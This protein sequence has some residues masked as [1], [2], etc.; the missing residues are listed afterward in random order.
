MYRPFL[1]ACVSASFLFC[2]FACEEANAT[3]EG[4][5]YRQKMFLAKRFVNKLKEGMGSA[6][7][8]MQ[9]LG[10]RESNILPDGEVLLLQP[11][12][13]RDR[14]RLDEVIYAYVH[15]QKILISLNDLSDVMRLAIDV[16]GRAARGW[17]LQEGRSFDLD[18]DR[19]TT[20]T[21]Q[22]EF[23]LSPD[24]LARDGDIFIPVDEVQAWMGI[25]F[26]VSVS[27]QEVKMKGDVPFPVEEEIARRK[28]EGNRRRILPPSLP[29]A[30]D[31]S[32][33]IGLPVVDVST[34][35][36]YRKSGGADKGIDNHT[37]FVATTGDFAYGTLSTQSRFVNEKGLSSFRA[38]YKVESVEN[39]LL[40]PVKA[41]RVDIGDVTTTSLPIIG[42]NGQELGM[43]ITNTDP[44]RR[45]LHPQ[46]GISGNAIPGWDVELYRE[47]QYIGLQRVGDDGFYEFSDVDLFGSD[48][49]FRLVFYGP[50]GERVEEDLYIPVEASALSRGG[51]VYDVSVSFNDEV[52]YDPDKASGYSSDAG[53]V[54]ISSIYE[55]P[56][57]EGLTGSAWFNTREEDGERVSAA[58]VGLSSTVREFL[59]NGDVA[60]DDDGDLTGRLSA[61]RDFGEHQFIGSLNYDDSGFNEVGVSN[62][63]GS[64]GYGLRLNGPVPLG[65]RRNPRYNLSQDY[66][67]QDGGQ[68][69][70]SSTAN[71]NAAISYLTMNGQVRHISASDEDEELSTFIGV[72]GSYRK[73]RLRLNADYDILPD[74]DLNSVTA[75][76]KWR[77]SNKLEF[78]VSAQQYP[79]EDRT[80]YSAR[81]DWQAGFVRISP[82]IRYNTED[83]FFAGLNTRFGLLHEPNRGDIR[84]MDKSLAN[85]GTV[86]AFVYLDKNGNGEFDGDDEPL[87]DIIVSAPQNS[88]RQVTDKH[89]IAL[90]S[91]M[92]KLKLT[93]VYIDQETLPDPAWVSGFEGL[94]ILPREGHVAQVEFPIHMSG[95]LDGVLY[96]NIASLPLEQQG[97][98]YIK[99]KPLYMR[100]VDL[101]LYNDRG[102]VQATATTDTGGFYY[103]TQ[104]PPG[105]YYLV[106]NEESAKRKNI[107]RPE[108][109]PVEIGYEGTVIYGNDIFVDTGEGDIPSQFMANLNDYTQNHPHIDFDQDYDLVLN[110]GAFN[111]RL[112]M[113]VVWYR[114]KTRYG[115][116]L[117]GGD[118]FVPPTQSLADANTGK[119]VL[120]VG[121]HDKDLSQ[122]YDRCRALMARDLYC[123]VEIFPGFI[124]Q[125]KLD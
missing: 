36:T 47:N 63:V 105:R 118:L 27:I 95:E 42:S 13:L 29:R 115:D 103:F 116:K 25:D 113:S 18:I 77:E 98:D 49:S 84:S 40:G 123:K 23:T 26:D 109:Q 120:R 11:F 48:N 45:F 44:L 97:E 69:T 122:A 60:I 31:E 58:S 72:T 117:L 17:Y 24:V 86:S 59:M 81:M 76:Y 5:R 90:F 99:P 94:S 74:A 32:S 1:L 85:V 12:L 111:S 114:L 57:S 108:P 39:D 22:G 54:N 41:R 67:L 9:R 21:D 91:N 38:S 51:G 104:I 7:K 79:G 89:G 14:M 112:M 80:D 10:V 100:N 121:I 101:E 46:T 15:N 33:L 2:G 16:D 3:T 55:A 78:E 83:D 106:I 75:S 102:E 65:L 107:I 28:R 62:N 64:Y 119:H 19:G 96:A 35:S 34:S 125:A 88:R 71:L 37:A 4:E 50:Q 92:T 93:D 20:V 110:L 73:H 43:R 82:T 8:R 124:K 68:S 52:L 87:E 61:R 30:E 53:G 66:T 6:D 70:L 56:L